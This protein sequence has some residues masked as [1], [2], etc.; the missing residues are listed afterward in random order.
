M[1]KINEI[2]EYLKEKDILTEENLKSFM[3]WFSE[4]EN[5]KVNELDHLPKSWEEFCNKH[6]LQSGETYIDSDSVFHSIFKDYT[7]N[8]I[9]DKV[10]LPNKKMA[11][12][13]LALMQLIQLRD[14]YR[15]GWIPNYT[16]NKL[17]FVIY[18][19]GNK[20]STCPGYSVNNIL[21]FQSAELEKM[22]L[23]NFKDLIETAKE[24]I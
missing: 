23:S 24:L 19:C 17:K 6:N 8:S 4:N 11:E 18:T 5:S 14:C 20:I 1:K 10:F 12:A 3:D 22:F 13:F 9:T 15:Q 21:S 7:R 2:I 16:D